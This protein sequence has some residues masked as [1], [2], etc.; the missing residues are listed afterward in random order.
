MKK[1]C[2]AEYTALETNAKCGTTCDNWPDGEAGDT[3]GN[4]KSCRINSI[5]SVAADVQ[6]DDAIACPNAGKNSTTCSDDSP[7]QKHCNLLETECGAWNTALNTYKTLKDC[8]AACSYF[9]TTAIVGAN[10]GNSLQCRNYHASLPDKTTHCPHAMALSGDGVCGAKCGAYCDR[11]MSNCK[12]SS[13]IFSSMGLCMA[14]CA[15]FPEGAL[16]DTASNTLECRAYHALVARTDPVLHCPHASTDGG[17]VC[18]TD[19]CDAYCDQMKANCGNEFSTSGT[20]DRDACKA[21][22]ATYP[23]EPSRANSGNSVQCRTYHATVANTNKPSSSTTHCPHAGVSGGSV[24]GTACEVYCDTFMSNCKA[25]VNAGSASGGSFGTTAA[26]TAGSNGNGGG[27]RQLHA[28]SSYATQAR[29]LAEGPNSF[30]NFFS[31][32]S[33]CVEQCSYFP[34]GN[35]SDTFGNTLSC[36]NYHANAAKNNAAL[37]CPHASPTG[38]GVCGTPCDYYCDVLL[39][40]CGADDVVPGGKIYADHAQCLDACSYFPVATGPGPIESGDSIQ[41]RTHYALI[42][43][44]S[45]TTPWCARASDVGD[46]P[47]ICASACENYCDIMTKNCNDIFVDKTACL[48]QCANFPTSGSKGVATGNTLQCRVY[49]AKVAKANAAVHCPHAAPLS[50]GG[51]CGS[52]CEHFCDVALNSCPADGENAIYKDR[53]QCLDACSYFPEG[54]QGAKSGN[55][56]TCR[57]HHANLARDAPQTHCSHASATGGGV[58]GDACAHY[59]NRVTKSCNSATIGADNTFFATDAECMTYCSSN[60]FKG[61]TP[62]VGSTIYENELEVTVGDSVACRTYHAGVASSQDPVL[63]CSHASP[64][65]ANVCV[66]PPQNDANAGENTNVGVIAGDAAS[67]SAANFCQINDPDYR[68]EQGLGDDMKIAWKFDTAKDSGSF[69]LVSKGRSWVAFGISE[70]PAPGTDYSTRMSGTWAVIGKPGISVAPYLISGYSGF[71]LDTDTLLSTKEVTQVSD[72]KGGTNTVLKFT[73]EKMSTITANHRINAKGSNM[74][75]F[76]R[77]VDNIFAPPQAHISKGAVAISW[78]D[79]GAQFVNTDFDPRL[80]KV[81]A[82]LMTLSWGILLPFGVL[83]AMTCKDVP[84]KNVWWFKMHRAVQ[85]TG[86]LVAIVAF[87]VVIMMVQKKN[88]DGHFAG[89]HEL[90]MII[91]LVVMIIGILQPLN[92]IFRPHPPKDRHDQSGRFVGTTEKTMGRAVWEFTHKGLGR[93]AIVAGM[94]NVWGGLQIID[95]DSFTALLGNT[96]QTGLSYFFFIAVI[97]AFAFVFFQRGRKAGGYKSVG[98]AVAASAYEMGSI[99]EESESN[100]RVSLASQQVAGV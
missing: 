91:G 15:A 99:K 67:K 39:K 1:F 53:A 98:E 40:N 14:A 54:A 77:G 58:C 3:S 21:A 84:P 96:F 37:H 55:S 5:N 50:G 12:G 34:E 82:V 71:T 68:C 29:R 4:S 27:R 90:H 93:F 61:D 24:C 87:T 100:R 22:C 52:G 62:A 45:D 66:V 32:R 56:L 97:C 83:I 43:K 49:H 7:C 75:K 94:A 44:A 26:P 80:L 78:A 33:T 73:V 88:P 72:G 38:A 76:A 60:D 13:A 70:E 2:G 41:C 57:L 59:C 31:D 36:R 48:T 18:G 23:D 9:P 28:G 92:A 10:S 6:D 16:S 85:T 95:K 30:P 11:A 8:L 81:H 25:P 86:L 79:G 63:H 51:Q 20:F 64:K 46:A 65:G 89:P 69:R 42:A 74:V 19:K 47:A 17:D 35:P